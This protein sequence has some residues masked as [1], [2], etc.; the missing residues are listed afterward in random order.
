MKDLIGQPLE[1]AKTRWQEAG[2][3]LPP[4]RITR[5]RPLSDESQRE[6]R[7]IRMSEDEW[8]AAFFDVSAPKEVSE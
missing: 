3:L 5:A 1:V 6:L 7:L 2:L 4:V 8:V